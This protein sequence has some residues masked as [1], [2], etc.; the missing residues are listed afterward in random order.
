MY[1]AFSSQI[2]ILW[3]RTASVVGVA[4]KKTFCELCI[5]LTSFTCW[6]FVHRFAKYLYSHRFVYLSSDVKCIVFCT[7][8]CRN[9][10]W[11]A[12][13]SWSNLVCLPEPLNYARKVKLNTI[14]SCDCEE[15]IWHLWQLDHIHIFYFRCVEN[16]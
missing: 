5:Y 6:I 2:N 9:P 14:I 7:H 15:R 13:G 8:S 4:H 10:L 16:P 1:N 3:N 12:G 11:I